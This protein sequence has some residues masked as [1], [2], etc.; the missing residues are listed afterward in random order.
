M[1]LNVIKWMKAINLEK[2]WL[3]P[4]TDSTIRETNW[5]K[6]NTNITR[7]WQERFVRNWNRAHQKQK[8]TWPDVDIDSTWAKWKCYSL[9][10]H[11]FLSV[12]CTFFQTQCLP[13]GASH[14]SVPRSFY[15]SEDYRSEKT[16][17]NGWKEVSLQWKQT[18]F[19]W[20]SVRLAKTTCQQ[21]RSEKNISV[22]ALKR[23]EYMRVHQTTYNDV[24]TRL[25]ILEITREIER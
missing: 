7:T 2:N 3:H 5:L 24:V 13:Y 21:G 9:R 20:Y 8:I 23:C 14:Y 4:N 22:L 16:R 17:R 12:R 11:M 18:T 19:R 15:L 10:R 1:T 25:F 6:K